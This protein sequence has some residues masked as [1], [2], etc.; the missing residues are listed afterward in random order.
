[1]PL[2]VGMFAMNEYCVSGHYVEVPL[3]REWILTDNLRPNHFDAR[4]GG[5][6]R[7]TGFAIADDPSVGLDPNQ[8][9]IAKVVEPHR[10]D[11]GDL[12]LPG[13]GGRYGTVVQQ[14]LAPDIASA[15]FSRLLLLN[16][17][18]NLQGIAQ[19]VEVVLQVV[20]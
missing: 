15:A 5:G 9:S 6:R 4:P 12:H 10:L 14:P 20:L 2:T 17:M 16:F 8:P 3:D 1:M 11:P 13:I 18:W 7:K 19:A